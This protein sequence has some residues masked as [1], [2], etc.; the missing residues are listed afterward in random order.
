MSPINHEERRQGIS[1]IYRRYRNA[2]P[3]WSDSRCLAEAKAEWH[4]MVDKK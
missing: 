2:N 1:F 3:K 4:R